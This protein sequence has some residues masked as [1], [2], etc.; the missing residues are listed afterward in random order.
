M[1]EEEKKIEEMKIEEVSKEDS[2]HISGLSDLKEVPVEDEHE[3]VIDVRVK[4]AVE[5]ST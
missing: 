3:D 4:A 1:E 2:C 5:A